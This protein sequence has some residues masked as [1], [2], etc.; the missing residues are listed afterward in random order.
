MT[1]RAGGV[2]GLAFEGGKA[3]HIR[4]YGGTFPAPA[5]PA[6]LQT[7]Q[8]T[9]KT[10]GAAGLGQGTIAITINPSVAVWQL[11][12]RLRDATTPTTVYSNWQDLGA[13]ATGSQVINFSVPVRLAQYVLD[14][15][16]NKDNNTIISSNPFLIGE[17][18]G[19]LGQSLALA[20]Y[21]AMSTTYLLNTTDATHSLLGSGQAGDGYNLGLTVS[22]YVT[23]YSDVGQ[24]PIA[25]GQPDDP[26]RT[27]A[28]TGSLMA[29]FGRLF[30]A[31]YGCPIALIGAAQGS[32]GVDYWAP[33]GT[34][35]T[36]F[37]DSV[38]TATGGVGGLGIL[39]YWQGHSDTGSTAL[40]WS[41]TLRG[42]LL[43]MQATYPSVT[44]KIIL[45]TIPN[46]T[47]TGWGGTYAI[48][49]IRQ[50]A[51]RLAT[52]MNATT[53]NPTLAYDPADLSTLE[54]V[55]P[56]NYGSRTAARHFFRMARKL[57]GATTVGT[58]GPLVSSCTRALGSAVVRLNITHAGGTTLKA[59][60]TGPTQPSEIAASSLVGQNTFKIFVDPVQYSGQGISSTP[61]TINA[62]TIV[63]ATHIDITLSAAPADSAALSVRVRPMVD[64]DTNQMFY[65]IYDDNTLPDGI[66]PGRALTMG[67]TNVEV[68]CP[69]P[70]QI[71]VNAITN[72]ATGAAVA[73]TGTYTG[74]A[75]TALN[76]AVDGGAF[77]A[78]TT[79]TISGGTFSFTIAAGV[80][81]DGYHRIG[82]QHSTTTA[83]VG[84]SGYFWTGAVPTFNPLLLNGTVAPVSWLDA[85]NVNTMFRD[86]FGTSVA[87]IGDQTY[88]AKDAS[89]NGGDWVCRNNPPAFTAYGPPW[90]ANRAQGKPALRFNNNAYVLQTFLDTSWSKFLDNSPL[91]IIVAWIPMA[92]SGASNMF[93]TTGNSNSITCFSNYNN[94][95]N[96]SRSNAFSIQN[97]SLIS[98]TTAKMVWRYSG[99]G[100]AG[101]HRAA[102]KVGTT[103]MVEDSADTLGIAAP[104]AW[105]DLS[106]GS[107]SNFDMLE[108]IWYPA[109][110]TDAQRDAAFTYLT[111][112]WG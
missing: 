109:V 58:D 35:N 40:S 70:Q 68:I 78:A 20:G 62:I 102:V 91:T 67:Y 14:L 50:A 57:L 69:A 1:L 54:G 15:R 77:V 49:G 19:M 22:P 10:G 48:N 84:W 3:D 29:E 64:S 16:A 74:T 79:P 95:I 108:F 83:V 2:Y 82:V 32:T 90:I 47:G 89:S 34:G 104:G 42:L 38:N 51:Q 23:V 101:G 52:V 33:G 43:D 61:L 31:E 44:F 94:T 24:T 11:A 80:V 55:H 81:T 111:A 88:L 63:D 5:S 107:S 103:A 87:Q 75:P 86:V 18:I 71:T 26:P 76:F 12:W 110:A 99:A 46:I 17:T 30:I 112:K 65:G 27:T 85:A 96:I 9:S 6:A 13:F 21:Q 98:G 106:I 73:V 56:N 66:V 92:T 100:I 60:V 37:K 93:Q 25:W 39:I 36:R 28:Y 105:A 45:S 72:K 8:R 97:G 59:Y 41:N 53:S 4:A 7:F